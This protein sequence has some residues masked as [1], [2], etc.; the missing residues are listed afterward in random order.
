MLV[1]L[2]K[3]KKGKNNQGN[4]RVVNADAKSRSTKTPEK[5]LREAERVEEE[6]VL[7]GMPPATSTFFSLFRLR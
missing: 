6:D 1:G 4:M 5:C 7:G 2:F 3:Y